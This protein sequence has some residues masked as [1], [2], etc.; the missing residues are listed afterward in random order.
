M[1]SRLCRFGQGVDDAP[2]RRSSEEQIENEIYKGHGS[3]GER[4]VPDHAQPTQKLHQVGL[5]KL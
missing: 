1:S 4:R 5:H 2:L 3:D